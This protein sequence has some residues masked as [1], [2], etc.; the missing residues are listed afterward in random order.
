MPWQQEMFLVHRTAWGWVLITFIWILFSSL[1][2]AFYSASNKITGHLE[3]VFAVSVKLRPTNLTYIS[4]YMLS[5]SELWVGILISQIS[6]EE[7]KP[8]EACL[9]FKLDFIPG[10]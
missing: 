4:L 7:A 2:P 5:D 3:K 6:R 9:L 8:S 1:I 10:I